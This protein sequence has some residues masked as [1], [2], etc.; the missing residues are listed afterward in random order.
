MLCSNQRSILSECP[1]PD[2][3]SG[4]HQRLVHRHGGECR[5]PDRGG[6]LLADTVSQ[7]NEHLTS[8]NFIQYHVPIK[9]VAPS[10]MIDTV[11]GPLKTGFIFVNFLSTETPGKVSL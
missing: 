1:H 10:V 4:R 2:T 6:G 5:C 3:V 11:V 8:G 9:K 7:Q